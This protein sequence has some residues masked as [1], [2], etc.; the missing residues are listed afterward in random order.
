M[1]KILKFHYNDVPSKPSR[2]EMWRHFC[3]DQ[4]LRQTHQ[5]TDHEM[6]MLERTALL[7]E[8][9]SAEDLLFILNAIRDEH[10]PG[11]ARIEREG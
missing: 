10:N 7:G 1:T 3:D 6:A 9:N 2:R 8:F 11:D 5:I 4:S